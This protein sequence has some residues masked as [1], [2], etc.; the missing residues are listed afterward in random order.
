MQS[1]FTTAY[2]DRYLSEN[3][4][5]TPHHC[6]TIIYFSVCS[7]TNVNIQQL[8]VELQM[9]TVIF[10]ATLSVSFMTAGDRLLIMKLSCHKVA[11][12]SA[13][14]LTGRCPHSGRVQSV[15]KD[16]SG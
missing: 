9:R 10:V 3:L 15:S 16:L 1:L 5:K 2:C 12:E 8:K 7:N 13:E 6:S 14:R 11:T 4:N